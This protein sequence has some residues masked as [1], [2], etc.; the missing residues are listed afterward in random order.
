MSI[1]LS[2]IHIFEYQVQGKHDRSS[3]SKQI[4]KDV[5]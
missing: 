5:T 1:S 4:E 2:I 3:F